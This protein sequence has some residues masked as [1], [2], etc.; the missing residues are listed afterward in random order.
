MNNH[1]KTCPYCQGD[2][3]VT[4]DWE[5]I[6]VGDVVIWKGYGNT[7]SYIVT[8]IESRIPIHSWI[9]EHDGD[10]FETYEANFGGFVKD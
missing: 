1:I 2:G 7:P 6:E 9:V 4:K 5:D 10:K 3:V 8:A